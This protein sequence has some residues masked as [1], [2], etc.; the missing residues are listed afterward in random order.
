M[1]IRKRVKI[2][3][4][5]TSQADDAIN[6]KKLDRARLSLFRDDEDEDDDADELPTRAL[7][8]KKDQS[9]IE[10][11]VVE[12]QTQTNYN[13]LFTRRSVPDRDAERVLNLEDMVQDGS[14]SHDEDDDVS[15]G[16]PGKK[17]IEEIKARRLKLQRHSQDTGTN[18]EK[19]YV[20]LLDKEEKLDIMNAMKRQGDDEEETHNLDLIDEE[21]LPLTSREI[22]LDQTQ[23]RQAITEAINIQDKEASDTWETQLLSKGSGLSQLPATV[24]AIPRLYFSDTDDKEDLSDTDELSKRVASIAVRQTQLER[25]IDALK[26]QRNQLKQEQDELTQQLLQWPLR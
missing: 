10:L 25:Q 5:S 18:D 1:N 20:S 22:L 3:V 7:K 19:V 15:V 26:S 8:K 11:P 4:Q 17:E 9:P 16:F 2:K 14:I 12:D 24:H 23:R 21:R 6:A 13:D